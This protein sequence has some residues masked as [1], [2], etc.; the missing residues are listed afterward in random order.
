MTSHDDKEMQKIHAH[1]HA[2]L[3][4]SA[5]LRTTAIE[6]LLI[7]KGLVDP[8]AIDAWIDVFSDEVGPKRGAAVVAKAWCD[9]AFRD[10][11]LADATSTI[12]AMGFE[13]ATT[14]H[15]TV[16]ENTPDVHN[17]IVCTLCSCYPLALLGL[18]PSWY[19]LAAY[20][21]RAVSAPR[22]VLAEFGVVLNDT[23]QVNVW[24]STA[25]VR[26]FILP[27]RPAGT[28]GWSEEKL[29]SIVT[30]NAMIGTQRQLLADAEGL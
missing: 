27:Q 20:R 15:L 6:S 10:A 7:E 16:I 25:E 13:T 1:L 14:A 8:A 19:K 5:A 12:N 17:L 30:R 2:H 18:P 22:A 21:S 3:P 4:S 11:L 23:V 9:P 29:A 28:D 24:D 26:Y